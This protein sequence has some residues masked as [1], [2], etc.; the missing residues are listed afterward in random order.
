MT[1]KQLTS[2]QDILL[3][4]IGPTSTLR[5]L[6]YCVVTGRAIPTSAEVERG[7]GIKWFNFTCEESEERE[8]HAVE[9][10]DVLEC[11][12]WII[13][14]VLRSLVPLLIALV[15]KGSSSISLILRIIVQH[16]LHLEDP[17]MF[18]QPEALASA[19]LGNDLGEMDDLFEMD[20][21][22]AVPLKEVKKFMKK[23]DH[24]KMLNSMTK[25]NPHKALK[26]LGGEMRCH[27]CGLV[28]YRSRCRSKGQHGVPS[29]R[30]ESKDLLSLF[31]AICP[32]SDDGSDLT[33]CSTC[34][35]AHYCSKQCQKAHWHAHKRNC[36]A[37]AKLR[38]SRRE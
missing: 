34:K 36:N 37:L 19:A 15:R 17:C 33:H 25:F 2:L 31:L 11:V 26:G 35:V 32:S 9:A 22:L 23:N 4:L 28:D 16:M 13:G 3:N 30:L 21:S 38:S 27:C 10:E 20:L 29:S 18:M 12:P 7:L 5:V 6:Y 8:L 24:M 14:E 1:E